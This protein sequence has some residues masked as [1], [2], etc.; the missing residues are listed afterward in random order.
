MHLPR[1]QTCLWNRLISTS[2]IPFALNKATWNLFQP[3]ET[4]TGQSTL[5]SLMCACL[6]SACLGST[7]VCLIWRSFPARACSTARRPPLMC[8]YLVF[9]VVL[10]SLSVIQCSGFT[11][12]PPLM[13]ACLVSAL[14][15]PVRSVTN[16]RSLGV[17]HDRALALRPPSVCACFVSAPSYL[18]VRRSDFSYPRYPHSV[19][20]DLE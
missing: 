7:N 4:K 1:Y 3:W 2:E 8:A 5:F 18:L 9:A 14:D 10:Y 12:H 15:V 11:Q 20:Q 19:W 13:S 6:V 17:R 16:V